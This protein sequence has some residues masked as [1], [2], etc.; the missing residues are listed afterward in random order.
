M[1]LNIS[2]NLTKTGTIRGG[3]MKSV[4]SISVPT[5]KDIKAINKNFPF[6]RIFGSFDFNEFFVKIMPVIIVVK[7]VK[8]L[9]S[10][11]A[12]ENVSILG[13]VPIKSGFIIKKIIKAISYGIHIAKKIDI[14]FVFDDG[15]TRELNEYIQHIIAG[16]IKI[17][18]RTLCVNASKG[19]LKS[20]FNKKEIVIPHHPE[21]RKI[22]ASPTVIN[23]FF[24]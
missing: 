13:I 1:A 20:I 2:K 11:I 7:I 19:E 9:K 15:Y 4:I 3:S 12:M 21:E 22:Q 5:V 23:S 17:R 8:M 18:P 24:L 14:I 6:H 10:N 16:G